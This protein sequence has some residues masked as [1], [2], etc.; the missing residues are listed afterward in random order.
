MN[1]AMERFN[2]EQEAMSRK[3]IEYEKLIQ[4]A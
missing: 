3:K 1:K 4:K 2:V